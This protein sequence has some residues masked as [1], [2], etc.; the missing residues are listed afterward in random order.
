MSNKEIAIVRLS[1]GEE[2]IGPTDSTS[3]KEVE[4]ENPFIIIPIGEGR[5]NCA[6]YMP[7]ASGVR[8]S[9]FIPKKFVM[10]VVTPHDNLV[11][12]YKEMTSTIITPQNEIIT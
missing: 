11:D 12:M 3:E 5:I 1:T 8:N 6:Q 4:I 9:L 2:L 10:W 7:Y